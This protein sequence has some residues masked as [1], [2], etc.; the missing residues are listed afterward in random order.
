MARGRPVF[1][2]AHYN[3]LAKQFR[4]QFALYLP[5]GINMHKLGAMEAR[6]AILNMALAMARR[7]QEDNPQFDPLMWLDECSTEGYPFSEFWE[8]S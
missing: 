2:R 6:G 7:L 8:E 5:G 4:E 3:I 1:H